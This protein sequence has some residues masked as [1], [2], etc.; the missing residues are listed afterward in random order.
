[1]HNPSQTAQR[2]DRAAEVKAARRRKPGS[3]VHAGLKLHVPDDMKDPA[4][5]YRWVNDVPGR[6]QALYAQDWDKVESTQIAEDGNGGGT[7]PTKFVGN[8]GGA[9]TSAVL[10]RKRREF[11]E[12]DR[13]ERFGALDETE[14]AIRR[15][16]ETKDPELSGAYT[17]NGSNNISRE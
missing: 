9:P 15:G 3:T 12:E 11:A 5:E 14:K 16:T 17:P 4:Y 8:V 1:M 10:M 2:P 6:V 7:I 13:R